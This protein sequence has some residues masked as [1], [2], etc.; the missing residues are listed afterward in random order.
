MSENDK[1]LW[2]KFYEMSPAE[3][4]AEEEDDLRRIEAGEMSEAEALQ[5]AA[6]WQGCVDTQLAGG[7]GAQKK[8]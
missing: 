3:V 2:Q 8:V 7:R 6:A 5:R 1:P 4:A